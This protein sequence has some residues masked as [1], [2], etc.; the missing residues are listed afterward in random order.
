MDAELDLL[1]GQIDLLD[2]KPADYS[3]PKGKFMGQGYRLEGDTVKPV[4]QKSAT[5]P[6]LFV[7]P[8]AF[9]FDT[10]FKDSLREF[11]FS[12]LPVFVYPQRVR[13]H[14]VVGLNHKLKKIEE[15]NMM[16]AFRNTEFVPLDN[17][18]VRRI[19][20][21]QFQALNNVKD[22]LTTLEAM[23]KRTGIHVVSFKNGVDSSITQKIFHVDLNLAIKKVQKLVKVPL[24]VK[25]TMALV[26]LAFDIEEKDFHRS[27]LLQVLNAEKYNEAVS[28]FMDFSERILN[29]GRVAID[30]DI[31]NRRLSEAEL[32]SAI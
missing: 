17:T 29:D 12:Q 23:D 26:S 2:K 25:Q 16:L 21:E 9:T 11:L 6:E 8:K 20:M 28:Y 32:F 24:N 4:Y 3:S 13:Q 22:T 18:D 19:I 7:E 15:A 10:F 1:P 27:K 30:Q 31:Y 14:M 5:K